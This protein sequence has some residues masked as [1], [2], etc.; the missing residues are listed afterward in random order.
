[1][2]GESAISSVTVVAN[3]LRLRGVALGVKEEIDMEL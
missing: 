1:M 3:S 2:V